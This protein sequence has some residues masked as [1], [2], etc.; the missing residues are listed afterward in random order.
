MEKHGIR[1]PLTDGPF[2]DILQADDDT[3][4]AQPPSFL[5]ERSEDSPVHPFDSDVHTLDTDDEQGWVVERNEK[6]V[7]TPRLVSSPDSDSSVTTTETPNSDFES[8][9][10]VYKWSTDT[11]PS[12][13]RVDPSNREVSLVA[14]PDAV[15]SDDY[16]DLYKA[17]G[18]GTC[19]EKHFLDGDGGTIDCSQPVPVTIAGARRIYQHTEGT[20]Y[21]DDVD[22]NDVQRA[23]QKYARLMKADSAVLGMDGTEPPTEPTDATYISGKAEYDDWTTVLVSL[24]VSP[25]DD[26]GRLVTP[27]VLVDDCLDAWQ[28]AR[29]KLPTDKYDLFVRYWLGTGTDDWGSPHI[30]CHLW[31]PDPDDD[32][33]RTDFRPT[34]ET[35]VQAS[36]FAPV[37]AHF[38]T[39]S[40]K[41]VQLTEGVVRV[42]NSPLLANPDRLGSRVTSDNPFGDV[43]DTAP[44]RLTDGDSVQSRG[45]IY[46]GTQHLGFALLG[47]ERPAHTE[48]AAFFEVG[49]MGR[50]TSHGAGGFYEF[51]D[52][53]D[54]LNESA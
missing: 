52:H 8:G 35:F 19:D 33:T 3:E 25:T 54:A 42:E 38:E 53:C 49:T 16:P 4:P 39:G 50:H 46:V 15:Q 32:V 51:A 21:A 14:P 37:E 12:A 26:D 34:V 24:R 48:A 18:C 17:C 10:G 28:E 40:G 23:S 44:E 9:T 13:Y 29:T 36:T 30:H 11:S 1:D 5:L 22:G 6:S 41:R 27:L 45:A 31:I 43:L 47:A 20:N 2:A 7:P